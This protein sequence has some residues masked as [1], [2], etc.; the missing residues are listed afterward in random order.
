MH[1]FVNQEKKIV[2]QT[3]KEKQTMIASGS[4]KS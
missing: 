4:L 2:I 3:H 1:A